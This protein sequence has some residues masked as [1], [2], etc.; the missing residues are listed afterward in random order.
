MSKRQKLLVFLIGTVILLAVLWV[1]Q[2]RSHKTLY[3]W[4]EAHKES[5][6][7]LIFAKE[8]RNS[9]VALFDD[10]DESIV[11]LRKA[12]Q[13]ER[14]SKL[15]ICDSRDG[16]LLDHKRKMRFIVET[17]GLPGIGYTEPLGDSYPI[18]RG[19]TGTIRL[20][21]TAFDSAPDEDNGL[22]DGPKN[23]DI[24]IPWENGRF[25]KGAEVQ[26]LLK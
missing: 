22:I 2:Q 11:V 18:S 26:D 6:S 24:I 7:E 12:G 4:V 21:Y 20:T 3:Q 1:F 5:G 15:S 19:Y 14:G 25:K 16:S 8:V 13:T 17:W 23:I 10:G 9:Y